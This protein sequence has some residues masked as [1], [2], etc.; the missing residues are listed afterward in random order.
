MT[1]K[2]RR[3]APNAPVRVVLNAIERGRVSASIT[4]ILSSRADARGALTA[5]GR[6]RY[7]GAP[8]TFASIADGAHAISVIAGGRVVARGIVPGID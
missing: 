5:S 4:L 7:R 8:V 2:V 1:V 3:L 6:V